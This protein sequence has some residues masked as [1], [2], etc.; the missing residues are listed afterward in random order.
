MSIRS[1]SKFRL[2]EALMRA[3]LPNPANV[4]FHVV[5]PFFVAGAR[6]LRSRGV[7]LSANPGCLVANKNRA[8]PL[9]KRCGSS[10]STPVLQSR[11]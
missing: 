11:P 10:D 4:W 6:R 3:L 8:E 1:I 7:R 9:F 5:R 2:R